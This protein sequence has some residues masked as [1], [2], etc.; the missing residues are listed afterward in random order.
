MSSLVEHP[1]AIALIVAYGLLLALT[2]V[3]F[4]RL[5]FCLGGPLSWK[6]RFTFL[7]ASVRIATFCLVLQNLNTTSYFWALF[8]FC[9]LLYLT[10]FTELMLFWARVHDSMRPPVEGS[11]RFSGRQRRVVQGVALLVAWGTYVGI[12]FVYLYNT[13][14]FTPVVSYVT[15]GFFAAAAVFFAVYGTLI[16]RQMRQ[17]PVR[18]PAVTARVRRVLAVAIIVT[19]AFGVRAVLNALLPSLLEHAQLTD[20]ESWAIYAAA[21]LGTEALPL[22]LVELLVVLPF[23][24]GA[25]GDVE[26]SVRKAYQKH[27]AYHSVSGSNLEMPV[28]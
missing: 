5:L 13:P 12:F 8:N 20:S 14:L 9:A 15:C 2:V 18:S 23:A 3:L 24:R 21:F 17:L 27:Y 28:N 26:S 4:V 1:I 22:F 6:P 16:Y 19:A 11:T 10:L 7:L 25:T